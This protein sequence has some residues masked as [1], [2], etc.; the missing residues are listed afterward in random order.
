MAEM[1]TNHVWEQL[2]E[3]I[4]ELKEMHIKDIEFHYDEAAAWFRNESS[5]H[6]IGKL[7]SLWPTQKESHPKEYG[8]STIRMMM[9]QGNI[10]CTEDVPKTIWEFQNYVLDD[11]GKI[12]KKNDHLIDC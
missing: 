1:T 2:H 7:Y 6:P 5:V 12:P 10:E 11:K 4:K 3:I 8:V 9:A